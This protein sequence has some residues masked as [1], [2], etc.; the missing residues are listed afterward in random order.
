MVS[1]PFGSVSSSHH[2]TMSD[3][4]Q[5]V[6]TLGTSCRYESDKALSV[7]I[8]TLLAKLFLT[9]AVLHQMNWKENKLLIFQICKSLVHFG[10][11][12]ISQHYSHSYH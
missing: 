9:R 10:M 2:S 1:I 5:S 6:L 11:L 7:L 8:S 3:K 12:T 4:K